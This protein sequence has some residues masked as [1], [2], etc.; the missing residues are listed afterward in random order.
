MLHVVH[1][2]LIISGCYPESTMRH[3]G[4]RSNVNG[5]TVRHVTVAEAARFLDVSVDTVGGLVQR[6]T[7]DSIR[8]DDTVYVLVDA[9]QL[10]SDGDRGPDDLRFL[11][12]IRD[13]IASLREQ[14]DQ[15]REANR[16]IRRTIAA[17]TESSPQPHLPRKPQT[18]ARW[19]EVELVYRRSDEHQ[20][21]GSERPWWRK[22][23]G[24]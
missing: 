13:Q 22:L 12:G 16:G 19:S 14:L 7:L 18:P 24:G 9:D 15:E 4:S 5:A 3:R 2:A 23:L 10:R 17:L 8:V 21:A 11:E 6:G 20:E 1:D